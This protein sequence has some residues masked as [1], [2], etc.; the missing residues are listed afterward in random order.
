MRAPYRS[1]PISGWVHEPAWGQQVSHDHP[2]PDGLSGWLDLSIV[3][4]T[5]ILVGGRR[6]KQNGI[7]SVHFFRL[8]DGRFAIPG[9]GL[10]GPVR[11]VLEIAAFGR[12]A[13]VDDVRYGIR[14]LSPGGRP[15][16]GTRLTE[17]VGGAIK[18]LVKSGWLRTVDG[19]R[20][21]QP[22]RWA[23]VHIDQIASLSRTNPRAWEGA[24]GPPRRGHTV[25]ERYAAW[26]AGGRPL[27]QTLHVDRNDGP[28]R[29][30]GG[31]IRIHYHRASPSPGAPGATTPARGEIVLTGKPSWGRADQANKKKY[32][33]FFFDPDPNQANWLDVEHVW[34]DFLLI[35]EP[36]AGQAGG[37]GNTSWPF[38]KARAFDQGDPV[39]VFYI[40]DPAGTRV[41]SF[42]LALMFRLAHRET[43][44]DLLMRANVH[45]TSESVLDVPSLL[46]GRA[47]DRTE[48]DKELWGLKGRV[49]F[50]P[51][52][53]EG[54]PGDA[55]Y[56][57]EVR[58][59][60]TVLGS[61]KAQFYPAYVRQSAQ[62]GNLAGRT[63]ASYTPGN[64]DARVSNPEL[65]GRKRYPAKQWDVPAPGAAGP[66]LQSILCTLGP[67][68]EFKGRLRFHN[69]NRVELGALIWALRLWAPGWGARPD[70]YHKVGMGKPLGFG[71]VEIRIADARIEMNALANG[72]RAFIAQ[73]GEPAAVEAAEKCA[74]AFVEYM[75]AQ[76]VA[77]KRPASTATWE[78]C[79][80][81]ELLLAMADPTKST[82]ISLTNMQL[83]PVNEFIQAKSANPPEVLPAYPRRSVRNN[84]GSPSRDNDD[85]TFPR[86]RGPAAAASARNDGA[87]QQREQR[88]PQPARAGGFL[89]RQGER[90]QHPDDG[91]AEVLE[92]VAPTATRMRVRFL[93]D[94]T[95][96]RVAVAGWT[97]VK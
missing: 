39:P 52:V 96:N 42:G 75:H 19:R 57:R 12:A 95:A 14:D 10:R 21:I 66:D 22:C 45:H 34:N 68:T 47:V 8:P 80:Q 41:A 1:I 31:A 67:G 4:K 65:A 33:F 16:Y 15:I 11:S 82:G 72:S 46:F 58:R 2:L 79:E 51:A 55:A 93:D 59:G 62:N 23:K 29:H 61:P 26:V 54:E 28:H 53:V 83:S 13:F 71:D 87:Q 40:M 89:F 32:E 94:N 48:D 44:A 85:D 25:Q 5:P 78:T 43:T 24:A 36:Q 49:A 7:T 60:P 92:N 64:G 88:A 27:A 9:S 18:Y 37:A 35:H 70:L 76:F 56:P 86:R 91:L 77:A 3:A 6:E 63:Y 38:W 69:L 50:E 20:M 17:T 73:G 97:R 84:G 90:V 81:I 30:R 74:D